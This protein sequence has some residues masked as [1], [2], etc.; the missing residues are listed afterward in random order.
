MPPPPQPQAPVVTKP[1]PPAVQPDSSSELAAM[2]AELDA[3]K[4]A[5]MADKK[6]PE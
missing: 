1:P 3:L 2:R 5:L 4:A 6:P